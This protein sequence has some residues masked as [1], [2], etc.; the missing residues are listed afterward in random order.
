MKYTGDSLK[1]ISFPIGGIGTGSIGLAGNG[2]LIDWEIFNR[3]DKGSISDYSHIAIRS[4]KS[5]GEIISKVLNGDIQKDLMGQYSKAKFTGYGYGP[6]SSTM[7][8]FPH[9]EKCEFT[10]EFPIAKIKFQEKTFPGEVSLIA[11]NPLIPL[12]CKNSSIPSAFFEIEIINTTEE[13]MEYETAFSLRNPFNV[14]KNKAVYD[15]KYPMIK[16]IHDGV[17]KKQPEYGDLTLA[18]DCNHVAMQSYW[19]RGGWQDG[20]AKFW[21]EFSSVVDI[22]E[23]IYPDSG[24]HD[25]CSIFGKVVIEPKEKKNI[26][27]VLSWNIPNNYNY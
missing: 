22:K 15:E 20:I 10:G 14:S 25:I 13:I 27:Y 9:F 4:L 6:K 18:C 12:D 5:N 16:L 26:R 8:G 3:P 21:N 2:R 1:E 7:C 11:F 17:E 24:S 23:R 19:Y